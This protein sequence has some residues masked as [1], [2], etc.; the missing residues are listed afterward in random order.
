[1]FYV[2]KA[3]KLT[4]KQIANEELALKAHRLSRHFICDLIFEIYDI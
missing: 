1:M 4:R 2:M 3:L